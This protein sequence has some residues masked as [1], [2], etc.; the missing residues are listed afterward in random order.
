MKRILITSALP[1][2]NGIKHLGNL[3]GSQLPADLY[4]RYMRAKGHEVSFICATD[5]HGTP[6]E[7]AAVENQTSVEDYCKKMWEIQKDLSEKFSLSFDFFGRSSST[8]NH[9]LTQEFALNLEQNNFIKVV[10][11]RQLYSKVDQRFLPDRYVI[12]TCPECSYERARGDQCENCTRQLVASELINPRSALSGSKDLE[13]KKTSH[14]YLMQSKLKDKLLEWIESKSKW[15]LLTTSIAKKWLLDGE[16]LQDRSITRD[17]AWGIPVEKDG[18]TWEGMENKVF[19]VWFDAPIAYISSTIDWAT[20]KK[21]DPNHWKSWWLEDHGAKDVYYVQFMAK[22]NIPFHTLS[23]PASLMGTKQSWK[24]VDYIKGF[25]WLTYEGGKFS[26]SQKRGVF[27]NEALD[28]YPADYWRWWLLS[29]APETSDADFTWNSFQSC[30][31]KDLADVLGNFVSRLTKFTTAKFGNSIPKGR[32]YSI[33]ELETISAVKEIFND[34]DQ[35]MTK[36]EIRKASSLLRKIWSIGN[37][38]LQRSQP[39]VVIKSDSEDAAKIVRFAFNLMFFFSEISEPFIPD[40]CEKIKDCIGKSRTN[41]SW[42][43]SRDFSSIF[44]TLSAG[45]AFQPIDN[46]FSK[47]EENRTIELQNQFRGTDPHSS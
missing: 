26:T 1:Y 41:L 17:L 30:V 21:K 15:P 34:Y 32:D 40:T 14:L 22:D 37:E 31:N 47:I 35:A 7:L 5:E 28:L 42:P 39:W 16:G 11:E 36:I 8:S 38:Y 3:V 43:S 19:Y 12:G 10:E 33:E 25:N 24:L 29:N 6:A 9:L 13:L 23:F 20:N 27:M 44:F 4:A 46:L 18:K 45:Q 2:I